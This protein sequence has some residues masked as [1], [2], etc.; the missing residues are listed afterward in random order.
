MRMGLQ[1]SPTWWT[2]D[3]GANVGTVA[4]VISAGGVGLFAWLVYR[5]L[6]VVRRSIVELMDRLAR[7][8]ERGRMIRLA[9]PPAGVPVV[10]D[11][12]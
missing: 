9:T 12:D 1:S 7:I 2:V 3:S 8:E 4:Q 5:E 6:V 11:D 10:V